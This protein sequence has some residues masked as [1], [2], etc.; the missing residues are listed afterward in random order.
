MHRFMEEAVHSGL[1]LIIREIDFIDLISRQ[2]CNKN[3]GILR[4]L[5]SEGFRNV[6]N[7]E[8]DRIGGF[9]SCELGKLSL[10]C[11]NYD[12]GNCGSLMSSLGEMGLGL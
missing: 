2:I 10:V 3:T 7:C 8:V 11:G 12:Q 9:A 6:T 5:A 4:L 1:S